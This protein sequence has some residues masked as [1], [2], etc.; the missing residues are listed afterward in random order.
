M[1]T[2]QSCDQD[3]QLC[4]LTCIGLNLPAG[5]TGRVLHHL[6]GLDI[7]D[8]VIM[9]ERRIA[10]SGTLTWPCTKTTLP[11]VLAHG[12]ELLPHHHHLRLAA[13]Q[14]PTERCINGVADHTKKQNQQKY[15][16]KQGHEDFDDP[17]HLALI[18]LF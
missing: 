1:R 3:Q 17:V 16:P 6:A 18:S 14:E 7:D 5:Q 8:L 13:C 15:K 2:S 4:E 11:E 9:G 12:A 10:F